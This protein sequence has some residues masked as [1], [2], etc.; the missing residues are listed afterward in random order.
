LADVYL[1]PDAPD[2]VLP[3]DLVLALARRHA[4]RAREV[5]AVD[6]SG[7]EARTY[8]IDGDLILKTQR[9]HRLRPRTS[10]E[11]EV[12]FL[13]ALE[14]DPEVSVPRVLGYGREGTVEYTLMTRM[15]GVAVRNADLSAGARHA[16]LVALGA[17]LRRIHALPQ[18]PF[19][20][21]ALL[22]GDRGAADF[23]E[24]MRESF[25]A[26]VS[27]LQAPGIPWPLPV[28]PDAVAERCLRELPP[29]GRLVALHSNPSAVHTFVDAGSGAF[30]GVIDFGDAYIGH[31]AFDLRSWPLAEDREAILQ[32]YGEHDPAFRAVWT[33]AVIL[34]DLTVLGWNRGGQDAALADLA[35][36][37]HEIA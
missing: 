3:A 2:P 6:E 27:A 10:L 33:I 11:K 16:A 20:A 5:R 29:P 1:Q 36:L 4:P 21:S 7:G 12:F 28:S 9:P 26:A 19:A 13:R 17:T 25:E 23:A 24:R 18:E 37:W 30:S 8:A 22:P 15:P 32:G 14:A 31:P 34:R 35:R